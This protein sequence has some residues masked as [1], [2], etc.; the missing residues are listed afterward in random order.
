M[1]TCK[2]DLL[3]AVSAVAMLLGCFSAQAA[4]CSAPSGGAEKIESTA[5]DSQFGPVAKPGKELR[6]AYVTKTLINEF[7]QDVAAGVRSEAGKYGIKVDVQAAKDESSMVEQLNLAQTVASQKPDVLLLSPQSD[8][9]LVP[10]IKA[11]RAANI[12][13]VIIDDARTPGANVYIGTDQVK[14][15]ADAATFLHEAYP[16]GGKVAQI[17]GIAGSPNARL[18]IQ[19][20]K[21]Q[22]KTYPGLQLVASQPGNWDRLT[23]LNA[24]S[25]ILRQHPDLVGI[26]ANNDGMALGVFEAVKSAGAA[27]KV[28]GGATA[29]SREAKKAVR[30][31]AMR[32][33]VAEFPVEE[34]RLGVSVALR[35]LGCQ[36]IPPWVVSPA[37]V[38]TKDNVGNYPD[39]QI[40]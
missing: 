35:L 3:A 8:S 16:N 9:N 13:T 20:F 38:L 15:G 4:D 31:G 22:L 30:A 6:F 1:R 7:W 36:P 14:I 2:R 26:Y 21:E 24:A 25:N 17:E 23:A 12:P 10:V 37:A 33:T 29:G 40:N 27:D 18:R 34:G 39:P 19:G 28:A 32:A 11:A 5:L